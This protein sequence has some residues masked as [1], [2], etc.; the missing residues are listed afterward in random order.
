MYVLIDLLADQLGR[1]ALTGP[2]G[3]SGSVGCFVS[4]QECFVQRKQGHY[5][6]IAAARDGG[7]GI[8]AQGFRRKSDFFTR[9]RK[10]LRARFAPDSGAWDFDASVF[11]SHGPRLRPT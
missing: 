4:L 8:L 9:T 2:V 5:Q 6:L 3:R 11:F 10:R 1:G 7:G